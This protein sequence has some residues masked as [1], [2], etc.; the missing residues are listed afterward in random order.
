MSNDKG[1]AQVKLTLR[2]MIVEEKKQKKRKSG[3]SPPPCF[4]FF[5]Y[6]ILLYEIFGVPEGSQST[7]TLL[8]IK[9]HQKKQRQ[10]KSSLILNLKHKVETALP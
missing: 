5:F 4:F 6:N 7:V 9:S 3:N 2:K 10:R 8:D 1:N